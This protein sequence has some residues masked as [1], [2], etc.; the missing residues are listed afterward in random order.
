MMLGKEASRRLPSCSGFIC[1]PFNDGSNVIEATGC[2]VLCVEDIGEQHLP[3]GF[4]LN[5][6]SSCSDTPT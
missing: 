1:G 2:V 4:W 3:A 5:S 6:T